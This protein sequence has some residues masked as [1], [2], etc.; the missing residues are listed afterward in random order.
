M[1]RRLPIRKKA[2]REPCRLAVASLRVS[3]C[4]RNP[5]HRP[6]KYQP[7]DLGR[8]GGL[9]DAMTIMS[10]LAPSQREVLVNLGNRYAV[11]GPS[12]GLPRPIHF[13]PD[14]DSDILP[15]VDDEGEVAEERIAQTLRIH[16]MERLTASEGSPRADVE[17][18]DG[19]GNRLLIEIK[20]RERDPKVQDI[21]QGHQRLS[22]AANMG[23][24]LELWY[25]NIERLKLVVMHLDR[26]RL[27]IDE[28][29][30]LDVW[31]KTADGVFDRAKVVDEVENWVRRVEALYDDIQTW[32]ADQPDLRFEQTRTITMS[33]ELMLKFAVTDRDLPV[34]DVIDDDQVIASFVP[35]GL[36]LVGS[37]GRID[38]ITRERTDVLVALGGTGNL[39]WRVTSSEDRH[40]RVPFDGKVLLKLL[41]KP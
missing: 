5:G 29:A 10:T 40:R 38:V 8:E 18:R 34:L 7:C 16:G 30:P 22:E 4:F 11:F 17:L 36:W 31:E 26:S 37:W 3:E 2:G 15:S 9:P 39:E 25:F 13:R 20:V 19:D 23:H 33:E 32:L 41:A 1:G 35:R 21:E 6:S 27:Q 12:S 14:T 24:A 28:L